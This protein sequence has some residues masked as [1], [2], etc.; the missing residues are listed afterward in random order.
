MMIHVAAEGEVLRHGWY[1]NSRAIQPRLA[2]YPAD[3]EVFCT[4]LLNHNG[5]DMTPKTANRDQL[6]AV[7]MSDFVCQQPV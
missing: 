4:L 2:L 7:H 3:D 6:D 1:K 5:R